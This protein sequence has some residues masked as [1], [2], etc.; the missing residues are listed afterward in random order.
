MVSLEHSCVLQLYIYLCSHLQGGEQRRQALRD[1]LDRDPRL[2]ALVGRRAEQQRQRA[3]LAGHE[4]AR[5]QLQVLQ[6]DLQ[7]ET[8]ILPMMLLAG[9]ASHNSRSLH[10]LLKWAPLRCKHERRARAL[11]SPSGSFL[12][13]FDP[14]PRPNP[15]AL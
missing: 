7:G 13:M 8:G 9:E 11:R 10:R 4:A 5:V 14:D 6:I 3:V 15:S 1:V 2:H 12:D